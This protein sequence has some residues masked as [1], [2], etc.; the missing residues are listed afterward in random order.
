MRYEIH[1]NTPRSVHIFFPEVLR[2][3]KGTIT[4]SYR[5]TSTFLRFSFPDYSFHKY[6]DPVFLFQNLTLTLVPVSLMF[7]KFPG[8]KSGDQ[9]LSSFNVLFTLRPTT[10]SANRSYI[11]INVHT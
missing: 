8:V 10:V 7:V 2:Y 3:F 9:N 5:L 4:L 11:Y 1:Y 6:R